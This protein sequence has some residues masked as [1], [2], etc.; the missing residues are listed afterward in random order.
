MCRGCLAE[1]SVLIIRAFS[2]ATGRDPTSAIVGSEAH[3]DVDGEGGVV[4][5]E[6]ELGGVVE[7]ASEADVGGGEECAVIIDG[8]GTDYQGVGEHGVFIVVDIFVCAPVSHAEERGQVK[9]PAVR[10]YSPVMRVTSSE[11]V[12][13]II[14]IECAHHHVVVNRHLYVEFREVES[15]F[16]TVECQTSHP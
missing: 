9:R 8:S 12:V 2:V 13:F 15:G 14:E 11:L 1:D 7:S 6:D 10:A 16:V 5:E 4:V 3:A